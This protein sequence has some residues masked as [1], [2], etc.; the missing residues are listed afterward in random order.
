[1]SE[2]VQRATMSWLTYKTDIL[3][4]CLLWSTAAAVVVVGAA[5]HWRLYPLGFSKAQESAERWVRG[6]LMRRVGDRIFA[7]LGVLRR[8]LVLK[9]LRLFFRDTT[10]WSQLLLLA[11]LV[12]VYVFNIKFLPLKGDGMTFFLR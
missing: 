12:V 9:E 1:P 6:T 4:W 11:V 5:F 10:Q 3:P 2:W 7:P 8:E